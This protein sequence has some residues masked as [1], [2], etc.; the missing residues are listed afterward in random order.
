MATAADRR[1]VNHFV[2]VILLLHAVV[3]GFF[4]LARVI[5]ART[6][7]HFVQADRAAV[8]AIDQRIAPF[9]RVAVAGADNSELASAEVPAGGAKAAAQPLDLNGKATFDLTCHVCH[10]TGVSGAPRVG[11]S[12]AWAPRLAKGKAVLYEH[13]LKGF[14]GNQG[15]MPPKSGR[16]D[17]SD[18]SIR[19]AVDF[20]ATKS[21]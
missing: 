9:A 14:Q 11:D 5:G 20:M 16:P 17:L 4:V 1:F 21:G 8:Q 12:A 6:Q 2:I 15:V 13:V 10:A 19:Q 3:I 18:R 7:A